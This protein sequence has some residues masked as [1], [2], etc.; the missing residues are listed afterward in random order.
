MTSDVNRAQKEKSKY[1][2]N[3]GKVIKESYINIQ[4]I[5]KRSNKLEKPIT[6]LDDDQFLELLELFYNYQNALE[7]P[8]EEFLKIKNKI[9]VLL[10]V[11][12]FNKQFNIDDSISRKKLD[13]LESIRDKKKRRMIYGVE[14][15]ISSRNEIDDL[16]IEF[17]VSEKERK[18]FYKLIEVYDKIKNID[19]DKLD[20]KDPN[21]QIR[22]IYLDMR[23]NNYLLNIN[24]LFSD[25]ATIIGLEERDYKKEQSINEFLNLEL[26]REA[27]KVEAKEKKVVRRQEEKEKERGKKQRMKN[28][29]NRKMQESK[30]GKFDV[31]FFVGGK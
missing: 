16:D 22:K 18:Y 11:L 6:Y 21:N 24:S 2:K 7:P 17:F 28:K 23:N 10:E 3:T 13:K 29:R 15:L 14:T 26:E 25:I 12:K 19:F 30:Y 9:E 4:Q 31:D 8:K 27:K 1:V 5:V 20:L